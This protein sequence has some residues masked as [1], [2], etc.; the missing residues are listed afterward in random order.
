MT[1]AILFLHGMIT[2]YIMV[3]DLPFRPEDWAYLPEGIL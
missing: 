1:D 2:W 3:F